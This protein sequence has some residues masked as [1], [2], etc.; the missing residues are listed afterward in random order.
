MVFI[1]IVGFAVLCGAGAI[2]VLLAGWESEEGHLQESLHVDVASMRGIGETAEV[3]SEE[4]TRELKR[5][6]ALVAVP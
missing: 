4:E 3:V 1:M 6:H 5:E 2:L